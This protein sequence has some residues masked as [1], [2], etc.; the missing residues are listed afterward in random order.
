LVNETD[1]GFLFFALECRFV[2]Q[3]VIGQNVYIVFG[4]D[5]NG[6]LILLPGSE[7]KLRPDLIEEAAFRLDDSND[8]R[9]IVKVEEELFALV[10][11]FQTSLDLFKR[12]AE[13]GQELM[14]FFK[15]IFCK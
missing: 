6:L 13:I 15:L 2:H 4:P 3:H 5:L 14:K 8:L 11:L 7:Q 10:I 9:K 12:R 1:P